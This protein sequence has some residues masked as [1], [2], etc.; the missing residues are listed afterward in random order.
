MNQSLSALFQGIRRTLRDDVHPEL[1]S[2]HAR[3]Q[4]AGVI[5]ILGNLERSLAWSPD[6]QHERLRLLLAG[7]EAFIA[8]AAQAGVTLD[9]L[10]APAAEALLTQAGLAQAVREAEAQFA[11]LTDWLFDAATTLADDARAELD[12][13]LSDTLR[14]LL[15][16]ERKLTARAD[17]GSMTAGAS[18]PDA[19]K[20]RQ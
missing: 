7:S 9:G 19:S 14:Q 20:G 8:R 5:D 11:R 6:L 15:L 17:F 1:T 16:A 2:D 13:L 18:R 12:T 10:P 4:L 3:A